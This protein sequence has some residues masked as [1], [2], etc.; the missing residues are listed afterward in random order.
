MDRFEKRWRQRRHQAP[1]GP[2]PATVTVTVSKQVAVRVDP[3]RLWQ[4]VWDPAT[5]TLVLDEVVAAFTLAGT[6]ARQVGE[7]QVHIVAG[8]GGKLIG[9]IEEVIELGPGYRA[10]TRSR[11][12]A[13]PTTSTTLVLPLDQGGCML[14][15]RTE[16]LVPADAVSV[17]REEYTAQ[18]LLYL[19][20][21]RELA[22]R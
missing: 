2:G 15:H 20:R 22:E 1:G 6:P 3:D 12:T 14:R 8:E 16:L 11:S 13:L 17:V 7:M 5:S 9:M 18:T 4:L 10:V 19:S 21:V